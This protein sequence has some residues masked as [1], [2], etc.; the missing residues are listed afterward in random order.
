MATLDS[1][2]LGAVDL[3]KIDVEG[4]EYEVLL[5][6]EKLVRRLRP[7]VVVEQK[8]GNA[9]RYGRGQW[10][11]VQLLRRW[12]MRDARVIGGDHVMVW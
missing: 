5:G 11:A 8:P 4:Y 3:L 2:S 7:V 12:G 9:E 10:D 6:A 1:L